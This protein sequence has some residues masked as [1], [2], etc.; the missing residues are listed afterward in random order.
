MLSWMISQCRW[1]K[2]YSSV[3]AEH[4]GKWFLHSYFFPVSQV[5]YEAL[6][7]GVTYNS[8]LRTSPQQCLYMYI[9]CEKVNM[10]GNV[11]AVYYILRFRVERPV[12]EVLSISELAISLN[13]MNVERSK[14]DLQQHF[15]L[16]TRCQL[17]CSLLLLLLLLLLFS[18]RRKN[19]EL[20]T[21]LC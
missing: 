1:T 14:H 3:L 12:V 17:K 8:L 10:V 21:V 16:F 13:W 18:V 2:N 15:G 4:H 5:L 19:I 20:K 11:S 6:V 7:W 9:F